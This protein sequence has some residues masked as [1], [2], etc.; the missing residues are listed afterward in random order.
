ME[1]LDNV[2]EPIFCCS[3]AHPPAIAVVDQTFAVMA[4]KAG[5]VSRELRRLMADVGPHS[6]IPSVDLGPKAH[7]V[8]LQ[9][10][11]ARLELFAAA[12]V[13]LALAMTQQIIQDLP[14]MSTL[15]P[16]SGQALIQLSTVYHLACTSCRH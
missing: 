9:A 8:R 3:V 11:V 4:V 12:A 2:T 1:L 15:I 13:S 7:A 5:L 6:G 14:A 16:A 10:I